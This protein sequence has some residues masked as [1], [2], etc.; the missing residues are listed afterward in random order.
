MGYDVRQCASGCSL[1]HGRNTG[2][3]LAGHDLGLASW[4]NSSSDT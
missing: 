1:Q 4:L 2:D 3:V